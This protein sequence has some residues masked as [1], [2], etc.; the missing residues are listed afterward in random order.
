VAALSV[1]PGLVFSGSLDGHLRAYAAG[2]GRVL[3]DLPT[4]RDFDTVNGVAAHGG[5]MNG[6][7]P[8]ISGGMVF[9]NSG[10]SRFGQAGGNV[11]LAL[12]VY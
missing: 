4:A 3:W 12:S 6:A 5:A 10:Y 8:A 9:V 1:A 11:L 2:D 7:G